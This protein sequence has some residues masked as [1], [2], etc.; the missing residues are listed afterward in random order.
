MAVGRGQRAG[1]VEVACALD[2][3]LLPLHEPAELRLELGLREAGRGEE[4]REVGADLRGVVADL[5]DV[6]EVVAVGRLVVLGGAALHPDREEH[7]HEDRE[8]DEPGEPQERRDPV[9]RAEPGP[10]WPAAAARAVAAR[11]PRSRARRRR[12]LARLVVDEVEV[13]NVVVVHGHV[14]PRRA[15]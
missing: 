2:V 14:G 13:Q 4:R 10:P 3:E 9:R 8:R 12:D 15:R 5:A 11:W 7:D 1:R 6:R